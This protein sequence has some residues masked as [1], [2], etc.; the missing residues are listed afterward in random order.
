[1][2]FRY[3][4]FIIFLLIALSF[5][6]ISWK[7]SYILWEYIIKYIVFPIVLLMLNYAFLKLILYII[8][9]YGNL[10]ILYNHNVILL[11]TTLIKVNYIEIINLDKITKFDMYIH[12]IIPNIMWYWTLVIEQNRETVRELNFVPDPNRVVRI[13]AKM[14]KG[15]LNEH[16]DSK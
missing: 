9:Y 2:V 14:K 5:Y 6:I 11:R 1:M 15:P 4:K 12:W 13:I 16:I 3:F 8:S 10:V 7:A